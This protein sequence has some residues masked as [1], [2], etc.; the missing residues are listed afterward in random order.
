MNLTIVTGI[1]D[2]GRDKAGEGFARPFEHY[3]DKFV[4]L[5]QADVPMFIYIEKKY[6]DL[7]FFVEENLAFKYKKSLNQK[8]K[9]IIFYPKY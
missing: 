6:E 1:W 5:L 2:L 4:E 9:L 3:K 7:V 8:A